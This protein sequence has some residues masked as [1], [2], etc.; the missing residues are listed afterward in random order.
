MGRYFK[1]Q[2]TIL[3]G[4]TILFCLV[5]LPYSRADND[6]QSAPVV[7][8]HEIAW[9]GTSLSDQQQWI[10]ICNVDPEA[11]D[12]EGWTIRTESG[13]LDIPLRGT[14]PSGVTLLLANLD[15]GE[16]PGVRVQKTF[17]GHL[18]REGEILK[19]ICP[20]GRIV[21]RVDQWY[22][23]HPE[24]YA[25]MQ[26]VFPYQEGD[27][28]DSWTTSFVRYDLGYGTPGFRDVTHATPERLHQVYHGP[29]TINVYFN[30]A[31]RTE[32]A[33][34]GNEA[35]YRVD[36]QE[37]LR[38]R[39]RQ[40]TNRIDVAA[41]EI[42]LPDLFD[43]LM[44]RAEE[45]VRV[46]VLIDAK[47]P[48]DDFRQ[49]RYDLMRIGVER[50]LRGRDGVFRSG[51]NLEVFANSPLFAVED[52]ERRVIYGLPPKPEGIEEAQLR[53][54]GR[55]VRGP[56]LTPGE[57]R[58]DGSYAHPGTQ[59]HHKFFIFDDER[60]WTG[61]GNFTVTGLY[62]SEE[63]RRKGLLEGN[64]NNAVEINDP[65][66]AELFRDEFNVLWGGDDLKPNPESARF[67]NRKPQGRTP[68]RLRVGTCVVDIYFSPGSEVIPSISRYVE[69]NTLESM[70]F[71]IFAWSDY[72]LE[73]VTKI[74]WE[75]SDQDLEGERTDFD[76]KGV[77]HFWDEWWTPSWNMRGLEA[78]QTS[79]AHPNIRWRHPP[80]VFPDD[81][82]IRKLHHKYMILD[83][84]VPRRGT[85]ITG[86][87]N[88]SAA[89]NNSNDENTL[90]IFCDRIANQY[91]QEFYAR[92]IRAG[93]FVE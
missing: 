82:E 35:N 10:E 87:A 17:S 85:V 19:L 84:R 2:Q 27:R 92:F 68:R 8:F 7:V 77:M 34:T 86:S 73:R 12:L 33:E 6:N 80:P 93:G 64:V 58:E 83:A 20:E 24:D 88:W 42:N 74:K 4:V 45:G 21:D 28:G 29:G 16:L 53:V 37:M 11:V 15:E 39:I 67:S 90:F 59:M 54:G 62:G 78:P 61:S 70:Y 65:A 91:V 36:F 23:G 44:E 26:R 75:G 52:S 5:L 49:W 31:A 69:R 66:V 3:C 25:T 40:A 43:A 89:A 76:L 55:R 38:H 13:S 81:M 46:R 72:E 47:D 22:A 48:T 51:K 79:R 63:N 18:S 71:A 30:H 56:L 9:M 50:M 32:F 1:Y 60:I 57:R 14:L 41:Y